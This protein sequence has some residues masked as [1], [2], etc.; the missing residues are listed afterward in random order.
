MGGLLVLTPSVHVIEGPEGLRMDDKFHEGLRLHAAE[1]DGPLRAVIR[2]DTAPLPFSSIVDRNELPCELHVI[3]ANARIGAT[4]LEGAA[5]VLAAADDARQLH[6]PSVAA[7]VGAKLVYAIEYDLRTRL[8][9][10]RLDLA[11]RPLKLARSC[12][13]LLGQEIRRRRALKRADGI[14]A[15]GYPAAKAYSRVARDTLVYLDGRMNLES[16]ATAETL[17][18]RGRRTGPLRIVSA[19]RLVPMKGAQDLVPFARA[20]RDLGTE[21]RLDIYGD[22]PLASS[23]R[24][25]IARDDLGEIVKLHG[26]VDFAR[27][28]VPILQNEADLFYAP[29]RQSDPS[30]IYLEAMGCGLPVFGCS[31]RMW[32]PMCRQSK[33][34]WIGKSG[35][36]AGHASAISMLDR[37]SVLAAGARALAFARDHDFLGQFR[38]RMFHLG[39]FL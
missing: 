22:G 10:A 15:N 7:Q 16:M 6:L 5:V 24:A 1:W 33:G 13:W 4:E 8:Q 26:A 9:I 34:G 30:C 28:L 12:Q 39:V 3:D 35:D 17:A 11:G 19:G 32:V 21:F 27:E 18:L 14:Q 38:R 23:I 31:R 37:T 20:L 36:P 29:H 25:E 2:R